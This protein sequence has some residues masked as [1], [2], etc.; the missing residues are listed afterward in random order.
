MEPTKYIGQRKKLIKRLRDLVFQRAQL[1]SEIRQVRREMY[2]WDT[3]LVN[4]G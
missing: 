3:A 2:A 4:E 1:N